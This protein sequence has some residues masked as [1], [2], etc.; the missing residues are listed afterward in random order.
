[1]EVEKTLAGTCLYGNFLKNKPSY[2]LKYLLTVLF[3]FYFIERT[4]DCVHIA[5]AVRQ[6]IISARLPIAFTSVQRYAK[7]IVYSTRCLKNTVYITRSRKNK[8]VERH[9]ACCLC[10]LVSGV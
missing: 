3:N 4:E 7:T 5:Q 8:R 10:L 2:Q 9:V 6:A 1:M